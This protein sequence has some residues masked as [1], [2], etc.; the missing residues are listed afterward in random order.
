MSLTLYGYTFSPE[1]S[2]AL[3]AVYVVLVV[4]SGLSTLYLAQEL[5]AMMKALREEDEQ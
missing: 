5:D 2:V 3:I 4:V 1:L